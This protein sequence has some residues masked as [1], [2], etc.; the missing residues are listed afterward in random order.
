MATHTGTGIAAR[1]NVQKASLAVGA[2]F[3]LIGVLG[4]TVNFDQLQLAGHNSEAKLLGLFQV[5]ALHNT[6][7]LL[8]GGI[9]YLVLFVCGLLVPQDRP[10][11]SCRSMAST[12]ARTCSE[13]QPRHQARRYFSIVG[14]PN[15]ACAANASRG[16]GSRWIAEPFNDYCSARKTA[17]SARMKS[18]AMLVA[19][20]AVALVGTIAPLT[21]STRSLTV[22]SRLSFNPP[23]ASP[24]CQRE[25]PPDPWAR[26]FL[27][28]T[29]SQ[30]FCPY[31][32]PLKET[33]VTTLNQ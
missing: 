18:L 17:S 23:S 21:M 27:R 10:E 28:S 26:A 3:L 32:A 24:S 31:W 20:L 33:P 14:R 30:A 2:I 1:C 6:V 9:I 13:C 19:V 8:Y 25:R 22:K 11:T 12:T 4:F 15:R 5:S 29:R 16:E 7:N